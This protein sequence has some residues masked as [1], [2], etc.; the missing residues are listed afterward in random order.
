M[1]RVNVLSLI[2]FAWLLLMVGFMSVGIVLWVGVVDNEHKGRLTMAQR[3]DSLSNEL[4]ICQDKYKNLSES[5]ARH[6]EK[7]AFI[8]K[9][10]I[11]SWKGNHII[12][13]TSIPS[14]LH[15]HK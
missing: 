3:A 13:K 6:I 2:G 10:D 1:K 9:E 15:L 14:S 11:R 12:L 8:R 5:Y 4:R 7:C